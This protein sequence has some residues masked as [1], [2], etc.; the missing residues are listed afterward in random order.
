MIANNFERSR[1][2]LFDG[3][4]RTGLRRWRGHQRLQPDPRGRE[5]DRIDFT[6]HRGRQTSVA[7]G[8]NLDLTLAWLVENK[9]GVPL[10]DSP[11]QRIGAGNAARRKSGCS[12]MRI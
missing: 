12:A 1:K 3:Q 11:A 10:F 2:L 4:I 9:L 8:D 7:G 5:G 6:P